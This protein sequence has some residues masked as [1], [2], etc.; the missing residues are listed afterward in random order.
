MTSSRRRT[1]IRGFGLTTAALVSATALSGCGMMEWGAQFAPSSTP[2]TP[3]T[4]ASPAVV[5]SVVV[6]PAAAQGKATGSLTM[7]QPDMP[8]SGLNGT[9]TRTADQL[10]LSVANANPDF[11]SDASIQLSIDTAN[12]KVSTV[13]ISLGE[14][15]EGVT[16]AI[17]YSADAPVSGTSAKLSAS[18]QSYEVT[19]TGEAVTT[20]HGKKSKELIPITIKATCTV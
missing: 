20:R 2:W 1:L 6:S 5:P 17:T 4:S 14:D 11:Y 3:S 12:Q 15:S 10:K 9:C 18:G 16:W 7:Y 13:A 8:V 19:G